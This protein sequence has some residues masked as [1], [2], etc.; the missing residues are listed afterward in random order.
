MSPSPR[1]GLRG[2]RTEKQNLAAI[3][4]Y[5][6][7][8]EFAA[9]QTL[10][11]LVR[12]P[13]YWARDLP[14]CRGQNNFEEIEY[15]YCRDEI[16]AFEAVKVGLHDWYVEDSSKMWATGYDFPAVRAGKIIREEFPI[17]HPAAMTGWVM[18]LRRSK[19][20]DIR[21]RQVPA[22]Y[23]THERFARWNRFGHPATLT[24][25]SIG[26]PDVWWWHAEKARNT[27]EG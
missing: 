2:S 8:S 17:H 12:L 27:D 13:G 14:V 6:G 16:S 24:Q 19:F 26:S 20:Q 21:V 1:D 3:S 25:R 11:T 22:W 9:A 10:L 15:T 18:D 4:T 7:C 5:T 23:L